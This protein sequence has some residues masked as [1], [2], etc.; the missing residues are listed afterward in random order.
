MTLSDARQTK[1]RRTFETKLRGVVMITI[2]VTTAHGQLQAQ[3]QAE[4]EALLAVNLATNP[5]TKLTAAEEFFAKFPQSSS[6]LKIAEQVTTE[7]RKVRN[8]DVALI[9]VERAQTIFTAPAERDLLNPIAL[10]A[11][12][13]SNRTDDAF[14]LAVDLLAKNADDLGV[15]EQM[16]FAGSE[17]AR[18]KNRKHADVSLKYGERAIALIESGNKP[19]AMSD[20][21]WT[22]HQQHLGGLYQQVSILYLAKGNA[23]EAKS[24]LT[25][26]SSL[27]PRDPTNFA[28]LGRV[29]NSEYEAQQTLYQ[30]LP[31]GAGKQEALKKSEGLLDAII[32]AYARATALAMGSPEYQ[33]LIQQLVPDL[34]TYYKQRHNQST[35]GLQELIKRYR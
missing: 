13:N 11:Y 25:K 29:L 34:T 22:S 10:E 4:A 21:S 32:E 9:L 16:T 35:A 31:E 33:S 12:V 28:L 30:S 3:S 2:L 14:R 19:A 1:V 18:K 5:T 26:A 20:P 23:A 15:L 8:S 7:L 6:R 17:E 24:R 27:R